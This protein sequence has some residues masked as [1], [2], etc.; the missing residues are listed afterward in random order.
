[1]PNNMCPSVI[2]KQVTY[3]VK[4]K[5]CQLSRQCP[6]RPK[7]KKGKQRTE[8]YNL[9]YLLQFISI[10]VHIQGSNC[11]IATEL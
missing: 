1:M 7:N 5:H 9:F 11:E 6:A 10:Y 2:K 8:T 3:K 4:I